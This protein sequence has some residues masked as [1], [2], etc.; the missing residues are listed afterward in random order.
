MKI[1]DLCLIV[2]LFF[3]SCTVPEEFNT[4]TEPFFDNIVVRAAMVQDSIPENS[5]NPNDS[6]RN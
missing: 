2:F 4:S 5:F 1:I 6:P 3:I